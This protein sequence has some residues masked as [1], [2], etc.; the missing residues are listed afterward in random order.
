MK[1]Q[2]TVQKVTRCGIEQYQA[3]LFLNSKLVKTLTRWSK[4][5]AEQ[6]I[7]QEARK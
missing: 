2:Y 6:A 7:L 5:A 3:F 4:Y 1:Y